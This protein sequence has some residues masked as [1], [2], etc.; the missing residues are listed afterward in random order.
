M[1]TLFIGIVR[2]YATL[3]VLVHV[4]AALL[5]TQESLRPAWG[6][7]ELIE[8]A[9]LITTELVSNAI[10]HGRGGLARGDPRIAGPPAPPHG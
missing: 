4:T 5:L 3:F 7:D 6:Q 2:L 8:D 1:I 10:E 9:V